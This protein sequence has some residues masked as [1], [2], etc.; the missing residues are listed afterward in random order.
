MSQGFPAQGPWGQPWPT[1]PM[2][3]PVPAAK[4]SAAPFILGAL[5]VVA[6]AMLG[7]VAYSL[8]SGPDYQNDDYQP[9]PASQAVPPLPDIELAEID[10]LL[11]TNP[12][13]AQALPVP[14][15]CE[16]RNPDLTLPTATDEEVKAYIEDLMGCQMRVWDQPFRGTQRFEL[17]R[18]VVN[19]YHE[20]VTTPCGAGG[21]EAVGPNA[22][23][24]AAN[25]QVY[26]SRNL[27]QTR[28]ALAV[29]NRPRGVDTTMSH[30]FGHALQAR[31]GILLSEAIKSRREDRAGQLEL[32]RRQEAQ[33]DCFAGLF[34]QAIAESTDLSESDIATMTETRRAVGTDVALGRPDDPNV[35]S[36]H[37]HA[38]S[39]IYWF[40]TGLTTTDIGRCN[41]FTAPPEYV[42]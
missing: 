16:L 1:A 15:R 24:C 27:P 2:P 30:E 3:T 13:Y 10:A 28:P 12:V 29:L 42:R 17:V 32:S 33:A 34:I 18:P 4:R 31:T 11:T 41:T 21:E 5:V 19:I 6:L 7:L 40:Q 26:F 37:P 38:R 9:P 25:Q 23:Y 22:I 14:V 36:T 8:L 39:R 20:S 35:V